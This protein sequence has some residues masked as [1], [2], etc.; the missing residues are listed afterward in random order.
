[1]LGSRGS[2]K[3]GEGDGHLGR[4]AGGPKEGVRAVGDQ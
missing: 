3:E 1:V 2:Y 4:K